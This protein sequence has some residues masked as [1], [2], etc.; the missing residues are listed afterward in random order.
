MNKIRA[1]CLNC[2]DG[3]VQIPVIHWIKQRFDVDF[4]DMITEPGMD[5][6]IA[7]CNNSMEDI[8]RK[9]R[10]SV[11]NN[12]ARII[13]VTGHFGCIKNPVSE[14]VHKEQ[15]Q[16]SV[17]RLK[18]DFKELAIVGLWVNSDFKGEALKEEANS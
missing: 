3:R 10:L 4:V 8:N 1:V 17:E 5:E 11:K 7:D 14:S 16:K 6:F 15:I 18:N 12:N 13:V 9:V 2:I